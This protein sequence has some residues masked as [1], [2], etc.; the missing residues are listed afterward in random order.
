MLKVEVKN[1][2]G[3]SDKKITIFD[4]KGK[5]LMSNIA[6]CSNLGS[7]DSDDYIDHIILEMIIEVMK[8]KYKVKWV[9]WGA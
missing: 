9:G 3:S 4:E 7:S 2:K 5:V 6:D 1:T 8:I